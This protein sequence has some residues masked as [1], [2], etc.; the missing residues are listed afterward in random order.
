[1]MWE[2]FARAS[3]E[4]RKAG[5]LKRK[6]SEATGLVEPPHSCCGKMTKHLSRESFDA[7]VIELEPNSRARAAGAWSRGSSSR[8]TYHP[9]FRLPPAAAVT[10]GF[11]ASAVLF[12]VV[13][14]GLQ[15]QGSFS[16]EG[17]VCKKDKFW[18]YY[19]AQRAHPIFLLDSEH[20]PCSQFV[21]YD[22][23]L[24]FSELDR[25]NTSAAVPE[26]FSRNPLLSQTLK[27]YVV[28]GCA[29]ETPGA[30]MPDL[31]KMRALDYVDIS[32]TDFQGV[33]LVTTQVASEIVDKLPDRILG[34]DLSGVVYGAG[35]GRA[36]G[37]E[38]T[39]LGTE[40]VLPETAKKFTRLAKITYPNVLPAWVGARECGESG[41]DP[42]WGKL[43]SFK[44]TRT[45]PLPSN[46]GNLKHLVL[47]AMA[48]PVGTAEAEVSE[49]NCMI[50]Y[51][52][53]FT[54]DAGLRALVL[55]VSQ[56]FP[57]G[58]TEG[59]TSLQSFSVP[60]LNISDVSELPAGLKTMKKLE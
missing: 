13:I 31:A 32:R 45:G 55:N 50:E 27:T 48:A 29:F 12:A 23:C 17:D 16:A 10:L 33:G 40:N 24:G 21:V 52:P 59:L 18:D 28:S 30:S 3:P 26:Y 25:F 60:W 38:D 8:I 46:F 34:L 35:A 7:Y 56:I 22:Q 44:A 53:A 41:T 1:M 20:C 14:T 54:S 19:C 57:P 49:V 42:C 5:F 15:M 2:L 39:T 6:T 37:I 11:L 4:V 36:V 43:V 47:F 51:G 9:P 58:F